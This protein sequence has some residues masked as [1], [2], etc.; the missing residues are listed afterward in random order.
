MHRIINTYRAIASNKLLKLMVVLCCLFLRAEA[1]PDQNPTPNNINLAFPVYSQYLQNGLV[2]NP[3][4]S[5]TRGALSGFISYRKQWMGI[6]ESP[7]LQTMSLHTP[8][9]NE[10]DAV[11]FITQFMQYGFTKTTSLY[12]SYAHNIKFVRGKLSMGMKAGFDMSN[13]NFSNIKT[14]KPRDIVFTS[15]EDPYILPNFGAGVYYYDQRIYAGL[16][17][18][19]F[20]SYRKSSGNSAQA[21]HSFGDYDFII[22][23]G[24]LID[25]NE[26][27]KFKPSF[28]L[29][30]SLNETQKTKQ[31]DIS[32][33]F[34]F[35]DMI[36]GGLSWRTNEKALTGIV[37]INVNQQLMIGLSYDYPL[38]FMSSMRNGSAEFCL[39][40]EFGTKISAA[41]PRYF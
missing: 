13:S 24:G 39:R 22:S 32:A 6:A 20:L 23:G 41:N 3:A 14:V 35:A 16:S 30:Y 38:G 37:Q 11:G 40:Y 29:H 25:I 36:W 1:E 5:G 7:N 8:F 19:Q 27:I 4:Y 18:P 10:R 15:N 21:Y 28:L 33:N 9:K 31:F 34:I 2:I 12:G 26:L 17:V